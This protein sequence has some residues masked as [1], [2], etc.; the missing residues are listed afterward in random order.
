MVVNTITF[1]KKSWGQTDIVVVFFTIISATIR[2][3]ADNILIDP[4]T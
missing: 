3:V 1:L 4:C 2:R